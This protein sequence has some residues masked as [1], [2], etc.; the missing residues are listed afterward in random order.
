MGTRI[1]RV[2]RMINGFL[3]LRKI[4]DGGFKGNLIYENIDT[5]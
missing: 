5:A 3:L 2:G 1:G 4:W